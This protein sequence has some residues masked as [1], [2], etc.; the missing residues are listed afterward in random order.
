MGSYAT[1]LPL[2]LS[3]TQARGMVVKP[4]LIWE[5]PGVRL[6]RSSE[7]ERDAVLAETVI[8]NMTSGEPL[9]VRE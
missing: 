2:N 7:A 9:L 6:V 1:T 8:K 3:S 4:H 5:L